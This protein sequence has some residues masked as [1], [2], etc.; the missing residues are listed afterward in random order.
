MLL[1]VAG[2]M[3]ESWVGVAMQQHHQAQAANTGSKQTAA[4]IGSSSKQQ[5]G[6]TAAAR[7]GIAGLAG[8]NKMTRGIPNRRSAG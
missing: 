5:Q 4:G 1:K 6:Q 2:N 8:I 7:R 3:R